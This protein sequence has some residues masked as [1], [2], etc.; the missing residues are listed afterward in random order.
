[1]KKIFTFL[2]LAVALLHSNKVDA[3]DQKGKAAPNIKADLLK[4]SSDYQDDPLVLLESYKNYKNAQGN[5]EKTFVD[6]L[7]A[8]YSEK[9]EVSETGK[10]FCP[11]PAPTV[12]LNLVKGFNA[13]IKKEGDT[14][15]SIQARL[16]YIVGDLIQSISKEDIDS[17]NKGE[18]RLR[19][20]FL[21]YQIE[22]AKKNFAA[23][24]A[25]KEKSGF[26]GIDAYLKGVPIFVT[27]K[28]EDG[29]GS[30]NGAAL[31]K[32]KKNALKKQQ[33]K[34]FGDKKRLSADIKRFMSQTGSRKL[35]DFFERK[36]DEKDALF[37]ALVLFSDEH[38]SSEFIRLLKAGKISKEDYYFELAIR[39]Q[40]HELLDEDSKKTNNDDAWEQKHERY[41]TRL[42]TNEDHLV[43]IYDDTV[44][45][46][47]SATEAEWNEVNTIRFQLDDKIDF[48]KKHG[49]PVLEAMFKSEKAK[50]NLKKFNVNKI[51][52]DDNFK[53][54]LLDSFIKSGELDFSSFLKTHFGPTTGLPNLI[55]KKLANNISA[56]DKANIQERNSQG[57]T[58]GLAQTDFYLAKLLVSINP[59]SDFGEV[60]SDSEKDR[61]VLF[62][63]RP[64]GKVGDKA[65]VKTNVAD[66][67][68]EARKKY[69]E[70]KNKETKTAKAKEKKNW[71][72][73]TNF[74]GPNVTTKAAY[75]QAMETA[76]A[77]SK[78][79]HQ[80]FLHDKG[81]GS[82]LYLKQL[83]LQKDHDD[84]WMLNHV[85]QQSKKDQ[86]NNGDFFSSSV[87]PQEEVY[88]PQPSTPGEFMSDEEN[89]KLQA[90][91]LAYWNNRMPVGKT[92]ALE[93]ATDFNINGIDTE[94]QRRILEEIRRNSQVLPVAASPAWHPGP[95]SFENENK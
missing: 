5:V 37:N 1:M 22:N 76:K 71:I 3:V 55:A 11:K 62:F 21:P 61:Q 90:E 49:E 56:I 25:L 48:I 31:E 65:G 24:K 66:Y 83:E 35:K 89:K 82:E 54:N 72:D 58:K 87:K 53:K 88:T 7:N 33:N 80:K 26:T 36:K 47:G 81:K 74:N 73:V 52:I 51:V 17:I 50:N 27:S 13:E 10:L 46:K 23:K 44:L 86:G 84:E 34:R 42:K 4:K 45:E 30:F 8:T 15:N 59:Y 70:A 57:S 78:E 2:I 29:L 94:E 28:V 18:E 39:S 40:I 41:I 69:T 6:F 79:D 92:D 68:K 75:K 16:N 85:M 60:F 64:Q 38:N 63:A 43:K 9:V 77:K 67:I 20:Q 32:A 19:A 12:L 93:Y 91:T 95:S 14:I